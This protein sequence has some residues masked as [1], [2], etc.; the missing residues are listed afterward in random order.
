MAPSPPTGPGPAGGAALGGRQGGGINSPSLTPGEMGT[1][2]WRRRRGSYRSI[3][4][5]PPCFGSTQAASS[6]RSNTG[7]SLVNYIWGIIKSIQLAWSCR[8]P[9]P[10]M[11]AGQSCWHVVG[12]G[13]RDTS[14]ACSHGACGVPWHQEGSKLDLT[15]VF[16]LFPVL[17][18]TSF[19]G[20]RLFF[21]N[22]RS[23]TGAGKLRQGTPKSLSLLL[24]QK[25]RKSLQNNNFEKFS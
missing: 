9:I 20:E 8:D 7:I 21:L 24:G 15:F 14:F 11:A 17:N 19:P 6:S 4:Q 22:Q 13:G 25:K 1:V 12:P 18:Y 5:L 2:G 23:G 10:P 16:E 3:P